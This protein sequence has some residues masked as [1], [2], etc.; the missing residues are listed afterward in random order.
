[1]KKGVDLATA[2]SLL[3]VGVHYLFSE[4]TPQLPEESPGN[5]IKVFV[6]L[7]SLLQCV[8]SS[9]HNEHKFHFINVWELSIQGIWHRFEFTVS[10]T[11]TTCWKST[12]FEHGTN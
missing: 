7:A 1:M 2:M 6:S 4:E 5:W 8:V 11:V 3:V 10:S 9:L 12:T